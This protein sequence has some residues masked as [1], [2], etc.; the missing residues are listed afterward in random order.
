MQIVLICE[1][2]GWDWQTYMNQPR[3]FLDLIVEK[4]T[5]DNLKAK[6][7]SKKNR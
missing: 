1:M 2:Y 4:I 7:D 5:I 6:K 3:E